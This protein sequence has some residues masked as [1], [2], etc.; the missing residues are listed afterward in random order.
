M[1]NGVGSERGEEVNV[2]NAN[3]DKALLLYLKE[4]KKVIKKL[5]L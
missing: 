1:R 2:Y 4:R 5:K 3:K